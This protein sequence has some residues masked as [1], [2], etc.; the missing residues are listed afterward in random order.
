MDVHNNF[1]E[2]Y[3]DNKDYLEANK[4][5]ESVARVIW[6]SAKASAVHD[7]VTLVHHGILV[8]NKKVR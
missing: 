8:F 7:L 1:K 4:I 3:F 5:E 6:D 2:W